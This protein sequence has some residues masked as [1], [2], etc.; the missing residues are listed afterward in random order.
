MIKEQ[1]EKL[2]SFII[3]QNICNSLIQQRLLQTTGVFMRDL[4]RHMEMTRGE[5]ANGQEKLCTSM[6]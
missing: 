2:H 6:Q 3:T 5:R 4:Q 1:H